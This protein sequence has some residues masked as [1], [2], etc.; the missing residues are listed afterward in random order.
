MTVNLRHRWPLRGAASAPDSRSAGNR[1]DVAAVLGA[2]VDGGRAL[3]LTCPRCRR[4]SAWFWLDPSAPKLAWCRHSR[5]CGWR[6][7]I[8]DLA[9][10]EGQ[11]A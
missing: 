11:D 5:R 7:R 3:G 9:A 8:A 4:R 10:A 2:T 1:S 6:G